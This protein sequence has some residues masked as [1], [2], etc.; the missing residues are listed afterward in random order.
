MEHFNFL[1]LP[2]VVQ[3][4]VVYEIAHNSI[5]EADFINLN[6]YECGTSITNGV[7]DDSYIF[8]ENLKEYLSNFDPSK[9]Y[10]MGFRWK[11]PK[12]KNGYNSGGAYLLS[13]GAV[14]T[15]LSSV[16]QKTCKFDEIEDV[17]IGK[18]LASLG[19]IPIDTKD[20]NGGQRFIPHDFGNVFDGFFLD[21][22]EKMFD[23]PK[24]GFEAF[25]PELIL[26]H[27]IEPSTMRLVHF[28]RKHLKNK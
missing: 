26:L 1:G 5:P 15:L 6:K 10:Y 25:S 28:I 12:I 11:Y 17:G 18:C 3:D 27:H 9:P 8:A 22:R 24:K 16:Y 4:L 7:D 2:D 23:E 13:K 21:Q 14:A 20:K 19:I